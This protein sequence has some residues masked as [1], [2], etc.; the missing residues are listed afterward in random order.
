MVKAALGDCPFASLSA[1]GQDEPD[2][3]PLLPS[4]YSLTPISVP[5][6]MK[7]SKIK[8]VIALFHMDGCPHCQGLP[9][10]DGPVAK[11]AEGLCDF[12]QF[13]R[14]HP[15]LQDVANTDSND[16][17][18]SGFPTIVIITR[19]TWK[20]YNSGDRSVGALRQWIQSSLPGLAY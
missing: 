18:V 15:V 8:I 2:F 10:K 12:R 5:K 6:P 17:E 16:V 19:K 20:P 3:L 7:V 13:E 11:A 1:L 14:A 9:G 4:Q